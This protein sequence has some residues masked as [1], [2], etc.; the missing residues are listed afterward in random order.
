MNQI[1]QRDDSR[2][3]ALRRALIDAVEEAKEVRPASTR[4]RLALGVGVGVAVALGGTAL[5]VTL[6]VFAP[7]PLVGGSSIGSRVQLYESVGELV[8]DSGAVVVGSVT[9]QAPD[10]DGTTVSE[11]AVARSFTPPGLGTGLGGPAVDVPAGAV[12]R[13]RTDG[14]VTS[15]PAVTLEV[16]SAY[17]L[18][19]TPTGL[20]GAAGSEFFITGAGAGIYISDGDRFVRMVDDGDQL[21]EE[22]TEAS[23]AGPG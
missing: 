17:L 21:P 12:L 22:L 13:V 3:L 11:I 18:F 20:P 15:L 10:D 7:E 2:S 14:G 16:G 9:S 6:P 5:A 8:A 4:R 1:E 23:L 19:L